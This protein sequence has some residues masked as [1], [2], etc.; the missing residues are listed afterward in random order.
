MTGPADLTA[1][2]VVIALVLIASADVSG[3]VDV[4]DALSALPAE[5]L[6][7]P[8]GAGWI[9]NL[10]DPTLARLA[11][12]GVTL[13]ALAGLVGWRAGFGVVVVCGVYLLGIPQLAGPVV[14]SHHLLWFAALLALSP[15]GT[16]RITVPAMR[17]LVGAIFFFP[18]LHKLLAGWI[19][20]DVLRNHLYW[21]WAQSG[22]V[23]ELRVD[24]I[25]GLLEVAAAGV[26]V[27][28]LAMPA[29]VLLRPRLALALALLFH[30]G[31]ALVFDI[32][33][34]SLWLCYAVLLPWSV[35]V[36]RPEV[37]A[38]LRSQRL[39]KAGAGALLSV[40][41]IAGLSGETQAWPVACYPTFAEPV[42]D[43]MPTLVVVAVTVDGE[44]E[45]P[46]PPGQDRWGRY[47]RLAGIGGPVSEPA[48]AAL[49]AE[50]EVPERDAVVAVQ[51]WRGSLSVRPEDAGQPAERL[52]L[53]WE[54]SAESLGRSGGQ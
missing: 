6:R 38:S 45:V 35:W 1:A 9:A 16:H 53:L 3:A 27:V 26:V 20:G 15:A 36:D 12:G 47:W 46:L 44:R 11:Q 41:C 37:T 52:M 22:A 29:L 30:V 4:A 31:S 13:G 28:E 24:L 21:K 5:S 33:F 42:G 32:H 23:P 51:W 50:L 7:P 18:G 49:W 40:V 2:R 34:S 17:L 25:P 54:Q 48:L 10:I 43:T 19:G 14:H 8:L 39:A